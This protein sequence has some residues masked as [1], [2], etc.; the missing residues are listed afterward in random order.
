MNGSAITNK[1]E[2]GLIDCM[3]FNVVFNSISVISRR[4]VHL[5]MLSWSSYN[6]YSAQYSFQTTGCFP[7][8]PLSKQWTA[9]R[10]EWI[11]SQRL[12][13]ILGKNNGW[14]GD[15]TNDL[16]FSGPPRLRLSYRL[17][18]TEQ[19]ALKQFHDD[20]SQLTKTQN[21]VWIIEWCLTPLSTVFQLYNGDSWHFSYRSWVFTSTRMGLW[22]VLPMDTR[23]IKTEDTMQL[24]P[25]TP[26]LRFKHF[27]NEPRKIWIRG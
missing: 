3:V 23:T 24:E 15:R 13:L 2:K 14:A 26:E 19:R 22:R 20:S 10:E 5:S 4:P 21:M 25:R 18:Q 12:S 17:R 9:V 27:T 1:T 6:Q 7:T 11:L 8:L 16:L